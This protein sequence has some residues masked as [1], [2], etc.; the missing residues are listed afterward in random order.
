MNKV[1]SFG[2]CRFC[3]QNSL[4]DK[5]DF[6]TVEQAN[7]CATLHCNCIEAT[8]Y[9]VQKKAEEDR[10]QAIKRA[11]EQIENLFGGGSAS[12]GLLPVENIIKELILNSAIMIYDSLLKDVSINITS[13]LK[14]KISKSTKG[15]LTFVRSDAAVFKQEV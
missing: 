1:I 7:E 9:Q 10:Q 8:K 14:V 4:H 6:E 12:Y 13:C 11:E 15:K 3:G 2:S 5:D